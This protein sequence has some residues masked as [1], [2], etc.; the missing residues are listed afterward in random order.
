MKTNIRIVAALFCATLLATA[1]VRAG[2]QHAQIDFAAALGYEYDSN[3]NIAE[4]DT[5]TGEADSALQ[6]ELGLDGDIPLTEALSL[7]LGYG[8]S[9]TSYREFSAFDLGIHHGEAEIGYRLGGFDTA[10]ALRQ[11]VVLLDHDRF[12]E[13]RQIS[14]SMA[15]LF[16][17]HLYLRGAWTGAEKT[18][19]DY[20][21]RDANNDALQADA[22][23]LLDGMNRYFAFGL[24]TESERAMNDELDYDGTRIKA[25]YGHHLDWFSRGVDITGRVQFE[26]RDYV[27]VSEAIGGRR[28]DQRFRASLT[29]ELPLTGQFRLEGETQYATHDSNL[30]GAAYDETVYSVNLAAAF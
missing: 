19:A 12:L 27:T 10:L 29:A 25:S 13:I 20:P 7:K 28:H 14:P 23:I 4:L 9:Q 21:G 3:V 6:L 24:R 26:Q 5:S 30:P 17:E 15:R 1:P 18:Y 8:Y 22:Y 2:Q 11:F 16:G